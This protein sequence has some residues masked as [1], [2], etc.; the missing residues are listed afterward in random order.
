ME[1]DK[2][3]VSLS[4]PFGRPNVVPSRTEHLI[5]LNRG[6]NTGG[7]W[8]QGELD[9]LARTIANHSPA[10]G[11]PTRS[12]K[13]RLQVET[14]WGDQDGMVPKQGQGARF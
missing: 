1:S 4:H 11:T 2:V 7:E 13:G 14:W 6:C 5:C 10:R 3:R 8:F 9:L 12:G